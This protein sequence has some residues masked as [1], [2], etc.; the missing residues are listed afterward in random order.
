MRVIKHSITTLL[1]AG[2]LVGT[3]AS[4]GTT[5]APLP[6]REAAIG[7]GAGAMIGGLALGPAGAIL[8]VWLGGTLGDRWGS[9]QDRQQDQLVELSHREQEVNRLRGELL[10]ARDRLASA[11]A[12][13]QRLLAAR[14]EV[15]VDVLFRT[16]SSTLEPR[17][18]QRLQELAALLRGFPDL[19][20]RLSGHA[21]A[22]G[23]EAANLT[24]SR[25]R[26]EAVKQAL[27][28]AGLPA[29]RIDTAA[30]GEA[31]A[32]AGVGDTDGLALERRVSVQLLPTGQNLQASHLPH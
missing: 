4:A 28:A 19:A 10:A 6:Q 26:A 13:Q 18:E 11:R 5:E 8:G 24:L 25:Q 30:H 14:G 16:G 31:R 22:R 20:I 29:D 9:E 23:A 27:V 3:T 32:Q 15:A 21:D 7:A 1:L 17:A 2:L 12:D